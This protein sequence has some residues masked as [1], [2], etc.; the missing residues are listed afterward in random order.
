MLALT[1]TIN[2]FER[3]KNFYDVLD[4]DTSHF[5]NSND[6]CTP[7]E[8]VKEM[9]DAIPKTFWES[10]NLKILDSCCGNGNFHAYLL[11]KT[12]IK[13]LY[14]NEINPKRI[15]NVKKI[16]GNH[17]HLTT[18]DF[19]SFPENP[20]YD[21]VVS[22][23][24]YAKFTDGKRTSKNHNLSR[25]FILKALKI[26]K[27]NGYVLFIVP[28]NWMSFAD[29][30]HLP[31]ILSQYQFIHL[32]IS[33]AKK[34]FPKVGSSFTWFLLQ[35]TSNTKPFTVENHYVLKSKEK[36]KL[37]M[38]VSCIPLY[39]SKI[40]RNILRKTLHLPC[41]K[42]KIETSSN[43][44]RF[45]KKNLISKIRDAKFKYKLIH[46]PSQILYS[47]VPHK[48]QKGFKVFLSLSNQY[49]TFVEDCGMTQSVAFVRCDSKKHALQTKQE[50][51]NEVFIFLNNITRYGN[52][53][54]IRVLQ[55][56]PLLQNVQL[57]QKEKDF[58]HIFNTAYYKNKRNKK[59]YKSGS[60]E[61]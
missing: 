26:T 61:K 16:F 3:L 17:I 23:P 46:T 6:I 53:N 10:E 49:E 13:N 11:Q 52:F 37:D 43:L 42:Y 60:T 22:N 29:R 59:K 34:W 27:E 14:F 19:L 45:T 21:L 58:I 20:V 50:L 54:N 56:F 41:E 48:F 28:N 1:H 18:Q 47:S 7:L 31:K 15:A 40:V 2:S 35:K 33:G 24:P 55:N 32:N 12:N 9:V 4:F 38:G 8:C 25:D 44:H 30:N 51:D 5:V 36:A 57:N 39:Y